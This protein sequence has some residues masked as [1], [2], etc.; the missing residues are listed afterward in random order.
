MEFLILFI[1]IILIVL[2]CFVLGNSDKSKRKYNSRGF[3]HNKI[4]RNGTKYDDNG[5]DY[6]GFDANGYNQN[7]YNRKGKNCKG[8]YDRFFDTTS[9]ERE[10]FNNPEVYPIVLSTHARERFCERL[11]IKDSQKMEMLAREA[12]RFG[13][14]KR[15]IKKSSAFQVEEIENKYE[16]SV[17]LIYQNVIYIFSCDNVLKTL[18]KNDKIPL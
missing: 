7:G 4:H 17:V 8:Q 3:D 11:G 6:Y 5:F 14:S 2:I 10:G 18:Y 9:S 12:Y 15:Q 13:K 1:I 16:N